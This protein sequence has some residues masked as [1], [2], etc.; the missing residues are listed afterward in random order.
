MAISRE[1]A[2][3]HVEALTRKGWLK[4]GYR[5]LP[6][7]AAVE[8]VRPAEPLVPSPG[9]RFSVL[10]RDKFTCRYCG[11]KSPEVTLAADHVLPI[12]RGGR[13][14]LENLVTACSDCNL[15]KSDRLLTAIPA[16]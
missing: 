8:S 11:R 13:A 5:L 12:A 3:A 2:R 1:G 14:T 16:P 15:G 9:L 10:S 4:R 6:R 7:Y